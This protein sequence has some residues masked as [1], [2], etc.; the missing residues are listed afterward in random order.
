LEILKIEGHYPKELLYLIQACAKSWKWS[1]SRV[2]RL[3]LFIKVINFNLQLI[4]SLPF[5]SRML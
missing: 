1:L 2:F 5:S 3:S 4:S